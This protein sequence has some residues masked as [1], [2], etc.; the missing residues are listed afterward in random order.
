MQRTTGRLADG[1]E[2]IWYDADGTRRVAVPD[3]R[4][5]AQATSTSQMRL[6]PLT[7]EWIAVASHRQSRTYMPPADQC[8]LCPTTDGRLSEVPSSDYQVVAFEN[9]FPSLS[10]YLDDT[11]VTNLEG[12]EQTRP[13]AG[14]C[15]VICFTSSHDTSFAQL[16]SAE[17][18]L[19]VDAWADRT[20]D[21]SGIETVQHVFPF[22]NRGVEIGVTL[23]HPHGQ[24]YAY[25]FIPPRALTELTRAEAYA[26]EHDS[27]LF[28][29]T[30]K[31]EIADGSR[32]LID[33]SEWIAFVPFAARWPMEV[34]FYPKRQVPDL[35]G[36]DDAQRDDFT[37]VY[38]DILQRF[39]RAYTPPT[40]YIAAWQQAPVREHREQAWLHLE[41]YSVRRAEGKI[42]YLAGSESGQGAFVNDG[43][44][45][46]LAERLRDAA[47]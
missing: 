29:D 42:K 43:L 34:H 26:A 2:I 1:R 6:D 10:T 7:D 5:L 45:E 21:L 16:S 3:R 20:R 33:S 25:P 39:D 36:L 24:I 37:A 18:R 4:D 31:A 14:R 8:P 13:G 9:R 47:S 30:I 27:N 12:L 23:Q 44:P 32:V 35:P 38:L 15:E 22:E 28:G 41:L 46:Q 40:P 19:V 17:A 11:S